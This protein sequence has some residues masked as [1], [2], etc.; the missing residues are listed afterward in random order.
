LP[1]ML[2]DVLVNTDPDRVK[3][4]HR[5]IVH[6]ADRLQILLY[7]CHD[8]LFDGLGADRVITLRST[9]R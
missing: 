5:V 6:A 1:M 4:M 9:T 8:L 2:D 7:S 3:R